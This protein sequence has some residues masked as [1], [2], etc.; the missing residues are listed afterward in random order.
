MQCTDTHD[1]NEGITFTTD[2]CL[3]DEHTHC[4]LRDPRPHFH[5]LQVENQRA[6]TAI[7]TGIG[8]AYHRQ[9]NFSHEGTAGSQWAIDI[10]AIG[11]DH[12][13]DRAE[14]VVISHFHPDEDLN[15][16]FT[17][18]YL[19]HLDRAPSPPITLRS[20]VKL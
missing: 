14:L 20:R 17:Y 13:S 1:T 11:F 16:D 10:Q 12:S 7:I 3:H 2:A 18:T 6:E 5:R 19:N 4:N 15:T 8:H 9:I